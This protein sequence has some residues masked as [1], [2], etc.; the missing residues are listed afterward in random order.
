MT[1]SAFVRPVAADPL[2]GVSRPRAGGRQRSLPGDWD[3]ARR[4]LARG[5]ALS[6]FA[7]WLHYETRRAGGVA[8]AA[9]LA[10]RELALAAERHH[11]TRREI[12]KRG[13]RVYRRHVRAVRSGA[14]AAAYSRLQSA[15]AERRTLPRLRACERRDR[16]IV[17]RRR[18]GESVRGIARRE[19]C[20]VRTVHTAAARLTRLRAAVDRAN[21]RE[22]VSDPESVSNSDVS[23]PAEGRLRARKVRPS[24][25][26]L[27][28]GDRDQS[29]AA[30][31]ARRAA[32]MAG[33]GGMA[34]R[35]SGRSAGPRAALSPHVRL[36]RVGLALLWNDG[37]LRGDPDGLADRLKWEAAR[38]RI[39]Y[40]GRSVSAVADAALFL[41]RRGLSSRL[42]GR[43]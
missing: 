8:P 1:A 9:D 15:R 38:R 27:P 33:Y 29:A 23:T 26:H 10:R 6:R 39:P 18:K 32:R 30:G 2:A 13:G 34:G 36:R 19:R 25:V 4:S 17:A 22:S 21:L 24:A 20:D 41:W 28:A 7:S 11:V 16:R 3:G 14:W 42:S 31:T 43:W 40:D 5:A 37:A 12:R 35:R